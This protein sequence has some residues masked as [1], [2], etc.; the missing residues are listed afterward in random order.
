MKRIIIPIICFLLWIITTS[1]ILY[2]Q[3][4]NRY[5]IWQNAWYLDWARD[6]FEFLDTNIPEFEENKVTTTGE[7]FGFKYYNIA[8]IE[9][10]GVRTVE[11]SE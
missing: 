1:S 10:D 2:Y 6:V 4:E 3:I 11:L 8:V 9:V 7:N 5:V